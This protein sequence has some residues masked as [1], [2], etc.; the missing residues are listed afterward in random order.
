[1][2]ETVHVEILDQGRVARYPNDIQIGNLVVRKVWPNNDN[3][4][5]WMPRSSISDVVL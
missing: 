5:G 3:R 4:A 1:M 2:F